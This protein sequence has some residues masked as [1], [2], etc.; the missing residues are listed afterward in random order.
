MLFKYEKRCGTGPIW[1]LVDGLSGVEWTYAWAVL[2]TSVAD[3][4]EPDERLG[5]TLSDPEEGITSSTPYCPARLNLGDRSRKALLKG[6]TKAIRVVLAHLKRAD[7]DTPLPL[8][9]EAA[10]ILNDEGKTV[11]KLMAVR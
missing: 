9:V 5:V 6:E 11:E 2:Y 10:Y 4:G 7:D 3:D 1:A 8:A